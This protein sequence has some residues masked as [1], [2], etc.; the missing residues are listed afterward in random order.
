M[1][2]VI[3]L[4]TIEQV[5]YAADP[6]YMQYV[7]TSDAVCGHMQGGEGVYSV[8]VQM[9]RRQPGWIEYSKSILTELRYR[10]ARPAQHLDSF[11]EHFQALTNLCQRTSKHS[12]NICLRWNNS[13]RKCS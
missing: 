9:K 7:S 11:L 4:G 5:Y 1:I 8:L 13:S 12:V 2:G 10:R 6:Y 3:F